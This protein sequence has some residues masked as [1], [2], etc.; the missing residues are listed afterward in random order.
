MKITDDVRD[1]LTSRTSCEGSRL[2]LTGPRMDPKLYAKVD[3]VLQAIGGRWTTRE[4][5]HVFPVDAR[6]AVDAALA[7]GEV[8]TLREKQTQAQFFP[9]PESVVRRLLELADVAPGMEVLEPSA[10]A[11]AI[12]VALVEAGAVVDCIERDPAYAALLADVGAARVTV[13]D[14]LTLRPFPRFDRVVMNP[15]FTR[16]ADMKHVEHALALL[17]PDGLLVSVMSRA[18]LFAG[19]RT[20]AF[21]TLVES[22]RGTVELVDGGVFRA[23]GTDVGTVIVTLPA[24]RQPEAQPTVWPARETKPAAPRKRFEDPR[25]IAAEISARLRTAADAFD[26]VGRTLD[27]ARTGAGT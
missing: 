24:T 10:G 5:A 22:R 18:V 15:P 12:A 27:R 17:K 20:D 6:A 21:R 16:G 8:T 3:E 2:V 25:T 26:T 9:T 19:P 23:S 11:G 1:V 7:A 4:Q 14:F 13:A